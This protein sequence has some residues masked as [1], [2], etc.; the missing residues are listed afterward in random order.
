[1]PSNPPTP[2]QP[3]LSEKAS[4]ILDAAT[5]EFL[6]HGYVGTTMDR[7]AKT[8]GVSKP[9]VYSH[10]PNKEDLFAVLIERLAKQKYQA[11][12]QLD[13]PQAFQ[14][15]PEIFL[16]QV[17]TNILDVATEDPDFGAFMRLILGESGRFPELAQPYVENIAKPGLETLSQYFMSCPDLNV[18]DPEATA[19]IVV[20]SVVYYIILQEILHGKHVMPMKHDRLIDNLIGLITQAAS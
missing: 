12:F 19:R 10:F 3:P 15:K 1:M 14:A 11:V 6:E 8:A 13:D 5:Q 9:T 2:N 20:G 17:I 4:K 16:R 18:V 7:I